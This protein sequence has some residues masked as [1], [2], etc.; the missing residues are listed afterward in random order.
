MG[1]RDAV[2]YVAAAYL[3]ILAAIIL[4]VVLIGQKLTRIERDLERVEHELDE[5]DGRSPAA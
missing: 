4:Y 1:I 2:P 5:R 3:A